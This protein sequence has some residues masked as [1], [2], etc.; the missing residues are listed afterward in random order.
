VARF[1]YG[2][3]WNLERN[4]A[5]GGL[6]G[7][8]ADVARLLAM[9]DIGNSNRVTSARSLGFKIPGCG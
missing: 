2:G 8:V 4:D 3:F 5:G 1:G 9:L 6:S 7:S